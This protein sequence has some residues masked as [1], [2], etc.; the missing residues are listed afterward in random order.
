MNHRTLS[1]FLGAIVA[2]RKALFA[3]QPAVIPAD[4]VVEVPASPAFS[5]ETRYV[6]AIRGACGTTDASQLAALR[7]QRGRQVL[8]RVDRSAL[9]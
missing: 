4:F 9:R 7:V 5:H 8:V 6:H 3:G 2:G 1:A